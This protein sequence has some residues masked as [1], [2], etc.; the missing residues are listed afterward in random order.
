MKRKHVIGIGAALAGTFLSV[1]LAFLVLR[2]LGAIVGA[3][4]GPS[5]G[6][7]D[8]ARIFEQTRNAVITPHW[9]VPLMYC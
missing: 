4:T 8:F 2:H 1:L 3:L 7:I 9:L 6:D 5:G